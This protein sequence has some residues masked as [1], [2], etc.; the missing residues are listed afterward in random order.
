MRRRMMRGKRILNRSQA[1]QAVPVQ[2]PVVK[3]ERKGEKVYVTLEFE[4][5][6]WQ[7]TLVMFLML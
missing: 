7:R 4:R 1:L 5:P 3:S 6:G 2:A